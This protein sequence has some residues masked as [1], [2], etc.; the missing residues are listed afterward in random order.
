[1]CDYFLLE[2]IQKFCKKTHKFIR[3]F[4]IELSI[5]SSSFSWTIEPESDHISF[6]STDAN[7]DLQMCLYKPRTT[8]KH[9][10]LISLLLSPFGRPPSLWTLSCELS[11]FL[12]WNGTWQ[13]HMILLNPPSIQNYNAVYCIC[14]SQKDILKPIK[15]WWP[16]FFLLGVSVNPLHPSNTPYSFA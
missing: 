15:V 8:K 1:M 12:H 13:Y 4:S 6:S 16:N 2:L 7:V 10:S 5:L 3:D 14:Q 9:K 11:A